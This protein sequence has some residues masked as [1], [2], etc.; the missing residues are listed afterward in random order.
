MEGLNIFLRRCSSLQSWSTAPQRR[1][2]LLRSSLYS[3]QTT[4]TVQPVMLCIFHKWCRYV[5]PLSWPL[6]AYGCCLWP[7]H[8]LKFSF[9]RG[10]AGSFTHSFVVYALFS[11]KKASVQRMRSWRCASWPTRPWTLVNCLWRCPWM[12]NLTP[13][14]EKA[15]GHG[16]YGSAVFGST[17]KYNCHYLSTSHWAA[18]CQSTLSI[19]SVRDLDTQLPFLPTPC[20]KERSLQVSWLKLLEREFQQ[21]AIWGKGDRNN[22]SRC[23]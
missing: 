19:E 17:W 14:W 21:S 12:D 3:L 6:H 1:S 5:A 18:P 4:T 11:N 16:W 23:K 20:S 2:P 7:P 10:T 9:H 22:S 8:S 15:K 13:S